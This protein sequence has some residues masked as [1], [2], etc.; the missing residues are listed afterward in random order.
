METRSQSLEYTDEFKSK[1]GLCLRGAPRG[2]QV[3]IAKILDVTTRTL[4]SWK[5][6]CSSAPKKRGRKKTEV[7]LQEQL[8]IA[9]EWSKQCYPGSRPVI[10]A[11]KGQRSRVIR[12]V[13]K[14]L[15]ARRKG[16]FDRVRIEMR[17]S[18]T[19]HKPGTVLTMDGATIE[20]GDLIVYKDR[21]S[22][23]IESQRCDGSVKASDTLRLLAKLKATGRLP[24][25]AMSDNGSPFCAGAVEGFYGDNQIIHLKSLPRVPQHN[26]SC[27]NGVG[28]VKSGV[29]H[30]LEPEEAC[31]RLNQHRRRQR[32]DWKTPIQFEQENLRACTDTE[33]SKFYNA[34]RTA[35]SDA[36][37]GIISA[38]EIRKAE[39]EAI[40]QTM[41][42]FGLITRTRG[43]QRT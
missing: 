4:R 17:T 29:N 41:E 14:G 33:R 24:L 36:V 10:N 19:V 3:R 9:R 28:E 8:A 25:V 31:R 21:G 32:L 26:G 18:V 23:R 2:S 7:A 15:K 13:I 6:A 11:L 12:L 30:G 16:R 35:I 40:F 5:N 39:R 1:I 38:K 43:H 42:R 20:K 34:T 27:E 22:L 37:L